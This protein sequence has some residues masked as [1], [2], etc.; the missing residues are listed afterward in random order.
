[1]RRRT[2]DTL[3]H[4]FI[5][6]IFRSTHVRCQSQYDSI[7]MPNPWYTYLTRPID[8][9]LPFP[10]SD[11]NDKPTSCIVMAINFL[12]IALYV[13]LLVVLSLHLALKMIET[14]RVMKRFF[15]EKS[16]PQGSGAGNRCSERLESV[17]DSAS[18][19][20]AEPARGWFSML[21]RHLQD[22]KKLNGKIIIIGPTGTRVVDGPPPNTHTSHTFVDF[23]VNTPMKFLQNADYHGPVH[24]QRT[25]PVHAMRNIRFF[26]PVHYDSAVALAAESNIEFYGPLHS[27]SAAS[28]SNIP[29]VQIHGGT[30]DA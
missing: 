5:P 19:T 2:G 21:S 8:T 28:L 23:D 10:F 29:G 18:A 3:T 14:W 12:G 20:T 6:S 11:I 17:A 1:M 26:G 24:V 16:V 4:K 30:Y 13:C 27:R 9:G 22:M 7:I 25:T 15:G